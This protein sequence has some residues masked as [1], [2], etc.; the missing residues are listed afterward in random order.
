MDLE[1]I[2]IK[3]I[4]IFLD[5]IRTGSV[6]ELA[7]QRNMGPGQISKI[8]HSLENKIGFALLERSFL[9]VKTTAKAQDILPMF[10]EI[11]ANQE[12]FNSSFVKTQ[13]TPTLS[14]A[15]TSFFSTRFLP[16]L[17]SHFSKTYPNYKMRL[18]DLP[19][20]LFLSVALRGGFQICLHLRELDWPKTWTSIEVGKMSWLL[21]CRNGH[22]A[23]KDTD[24]PNPKA[25]QEVI[26]NMRNLTKYP[27]VFPVYWS[28]NG[29]TYGS[30]SFPLSQ[31]KRIRG[32]ETST[33]TSAV[34]VIRL[35]DHLG[36][37]P[38]IV[39]RPLLESGDLI[40]LKVPTIKP[41]SEAVFLT[42]KNEIVTQKMFTWLI[43]LC[44]ES[45]PSNT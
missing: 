31:D 18:L 20:D 36:F 37:V 28:Q 4:N 43:Q 15:T 45:L 38:E 35:T 19:P 34:E 39:A 5:L 8:I 22:P 27:F 21:C 44:E 14:I 7:R 41:V 24:T 13:S 3:E 10:Q 33:A 40:G 11:R 16:L 30:D 9:G 32:Y 12:A 6:R 29:L 23:L 1:E 25:L 2:K 26:T 17:F 42:V